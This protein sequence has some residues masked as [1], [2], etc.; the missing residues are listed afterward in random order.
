M[1][2]GYRLKSHLPSI[3]ANI[4]RKFFS[5][6]Y[7]LFLHL[8]PSLLWVIILAL[9]NRTEL[10]ILISIP[11]MYI[12]FNSVFSD[13]GESKFDSNVLQ[14]KLEANGFMKTDNNWENFFF[15]LIIL[16]LFKRFLINL[17]KFLWIPFK[18]AFIFYVLKYFGFNFYYIFNI[19]NNLSLGIIEWFYDKITNFFENFNN[20]DKSD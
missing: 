2:L 15:M 4:Y 11:A 12:L 18:V 1:L 6:S 17:F 7:R 5:L 13:P 3:N 16:A 10:K 20:N 14:A 9:L 19:L 8:K